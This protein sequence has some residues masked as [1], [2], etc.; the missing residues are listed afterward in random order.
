MVFKYGL[1]NDLHQ[2][3]HIHIKAI[4]RLKCSQTSQLIIVHNR[5]LTL[6]LENEK[7]PRKILSHYGPCTDLDHLTNTIF[8]ASQSASCSFSH[9]VVLQNKPSPSMR[10]IFLLLNSHSTFFRASYATVCNTQ[11]EKVIYKQSTSRSFVLRVPSFSFL[12][13]FRRSSVVQHF[14][15][16]FD[17]LSFFELSLWL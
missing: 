3:I 9:F 15:F 6:T 7:N 12:R 11:R 8:N 16:P 5:L 13:H 1:I 4:H 14:F 2:R 17:G 10:R